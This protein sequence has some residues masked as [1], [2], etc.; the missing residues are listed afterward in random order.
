MI[1]VNYPKC[2]LCVCVCAREHVLKTNSSICHLIIIISLTINLLS[3]IDNVSVTKPL[4]SIL[5]TISFMYFGC[6]KENRIL[7]VGGLKNELYGCR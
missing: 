3:P 4:D 6:I 5:L 1:T 7:G 2:V